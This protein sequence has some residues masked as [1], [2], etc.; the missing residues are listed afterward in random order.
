M[1]PQRRPPARSRRGAGGVWIGVGLIVL[2]AVA[3]LGFF[4]VPDGDTEGPEAVVVDDG[5]L[6]D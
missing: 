1:D 6:G 4:V 2:L 3:M 5:A